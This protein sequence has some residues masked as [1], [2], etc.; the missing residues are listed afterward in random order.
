MSVDRESELSLVAR[1]RARDA[2]AFDEAHAAF[3]TRLFN[4]L[5]RLARN[6]D[7]AEDLLEEVWLRLV[8]HA[9]RLRPDTA[10]GAWLF[11]V[12][13]NL[14]ISYCRSRALETG[15]AADSA[16]FWPS[17]PASGSPFEEAAA[18]ET[19]R[20]LERALASLPPSYREVLLLVAV[21][22]LSPA[23]AA[24]ICG[25]SGAALRQ[26]VHRARAMLLERLDAAPAPPRA[27]LREV[28]S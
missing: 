13:R 6:R 3:H 12:A 23:E 10:L 25:I 1:L 9:P 21:E 2:S 11:T 27:K 16:A 28:L 15:L 24:V 19:E 22:G 18:S 20:R 4:F 26:R 14:Y 5:A 17:L 8:S 7:V